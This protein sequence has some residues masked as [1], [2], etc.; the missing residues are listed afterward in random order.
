MYNE[1]D[2]AIRSPYNETQVYFPGERILAKKLEAIF[3]KKII[4]D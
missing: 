1:V 3:K 2:L 4:Q